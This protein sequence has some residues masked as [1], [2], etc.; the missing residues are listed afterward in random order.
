V[1]QKKYQFTKEIKKE[2]EKIEHEIEKL[3]SLRNKLE[4]ELTQEEVYSNPELAKNKNIDYDTTK[5]RLESL[6]SRWTT[7]N[8]E[9]EEIEKSFSL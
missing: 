5:Q 4:F 1:R 7:L 2:I 9:L 3:E 6:Y 8:H